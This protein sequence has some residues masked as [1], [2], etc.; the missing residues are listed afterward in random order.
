MYGYEIGSFVCGEVVLVDQG[1]VLLAA[2]A[3]LGLLL[4]VGAY[5]VLRGR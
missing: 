5:F 3:Q 1:L 2:W 4:A